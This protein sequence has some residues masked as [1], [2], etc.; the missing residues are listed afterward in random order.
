MPC[1]AGGFSRP[2][3]V[4]RLGTAAIV[5][6]IEANEAERAA[7]A[8]RLGLVAIDRLTA[9]VRLHAEFGRDLI[10]VTGR[11]EADVVQTCVVTLDALS[12]PRGRQFR[13]RFR[14]CVR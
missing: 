7:L 11:L 4:E 3:P 5:E 8:R 2:F 9:S 1:N 10:R 13:C 14:G 6:T 12:Q